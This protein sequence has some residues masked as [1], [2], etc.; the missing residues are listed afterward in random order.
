MTPRTIYASLTF[1]ASILLLS[2]P[3]FAQ[4]IAGVG[5]GTG[6]LQ[7]IIQWFVQNIVTG[8]IAAGILIVGL[9][10]I[11]THHALQSI[12]VMVL[13]ALVMAYYSDIAALFQVR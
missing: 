10:L 7:P 3:A 2:D 12:A 5:G 13:G 6:Y 1:A 9:L 11:W 4:A 8:I